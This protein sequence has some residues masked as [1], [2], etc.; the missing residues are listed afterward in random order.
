MRRLLRWQE[1]ASEQLSDTREK[2]CIAIA[3]KFQEKTNDSS[4]Q[5]VAPP[6]NT[7]EE[8]IISLLV[9]K[10]FYTLL[11][12][13]IVYSYAD[14]Q[15]LSGTVKDPSSN[16]PLIGATVNIKGTSTGTVTDEAGKFQL[17]V[18]Q[19]FPITLTI[20]YV[21][22]LSK[23]VVVKEGSSV[24]TIKLLPDKITLKEVRV[25]GS[26]LTEKEKQSPLTVESMDLIA[27]R[28][29]P[30]FNFYE[31]LGALKGVDITSAS[32]AF[33]IINTRGFN[34]TS[35]VRTLQMIDG[36]DNQAP[37]LNFSLGNFLGAPDLDVVRVDLVVGASSAYYGPNAFNGVISMATKDPFTTPGLS[38]SLKEGE[39]GL[40]EGAIRW[41]QVFKNKEGKEKFAYKLNGYY[42]KAYDWEANNLD[43]VYGSPEG[44]DNAG[45]YDAVNRYGDEFYFAHDFTGLLWQ[46]PGLGKI[47]RTGYLEKNLVDYNTNNG[48]LS[49]AFQYKITPD[50]RLILASNFG[51]GTTVYQGDNRYSLKNVFLFQNRI[52]LQKEDKFFLRAYATKENSGNS[53]DAYFTALQLEDE[54]KYVGDWGTDYAN[55][56]SQYGAP[57]IMQLPGYPPFQYPVP[58]WYSDSIRAILAKYPDIV[59]YYNQQARIYADDSSLYPG[60]HSWFIPGTHDFD[61]AFNSITSRETFAQGGTHLYDRSALYDVHGEYKFTPGF[62]DITVGGNFRQYRPNSHGTIFSDTSGEVITN[63]EFGIYTGLEKKFIIDQLKLNATCRMDKNQNF[64]FLFSPALSAVY[65]VNKQV[66]RV[67]FSSAIRN[68][69]LADQYLYYN[70]GPAILVGNISGFDSLVTIP[71]I[72]TSLNYHEWDSLRYFNVAPLQPEQVKTIEFGYRASL[73]DHFFVDAEYYHSWYHHFIGYKLGA[74]VT[75]NIFQQIQSVQPYRV[76]ANTNDMVTTQG[77]SVGINYFFKNFYTLSG[78]YSFNKL[79]RRGSA[80]PIIPAYNTPENKF[81]L[82]ISGRDIVT[83]LTFFNSLWK[84]LPIIP[85][86]HYSFSINY[87]WVQG[88]LFEGSPQFTGVVPSYATLDAQLNKQIPKLHLTVKIGASNLLSQKHFEAYGGPLVGRLAYIQVV[89]DLPGHR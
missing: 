57:Q 31:G 13:I 46:K 43:P 12:F 24:I 79:N 39:R 65:S 35:P 27:I 67:S 34:S 69:T 76:A 77:F 83:S 63:S 8:L 55:W 19:S 80:D 7:F 10:K 25:E 59:A 20:S 42:L 18:D 17:Q 15:D 23:E 45:G 82:G 1:F 52:E 74:V 44:S 89:V 26:R 6:Q 53:Y 61:T 40:F 81:N 30:A 37:G 86:R 68:P 75:S 56:Y 62:M 28:E 33:K 38:V 60:Q 21:G 78:N 58:D 71:S 88:F 64:D 49:A 4:Q 29:T 85:L 48:K 11:V 51:T 41:A 87:K 54:A 9:L 2:N 70:V 72:I 3:R 16:E 5:I 22:Y 36:V 14:A 84:K 50:V 47:Y 32:L 66:Y 73:F